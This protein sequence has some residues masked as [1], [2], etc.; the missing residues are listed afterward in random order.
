MLYTI[1]KV[2]AD[3]SKNPQPFPFCDLM[4]VLIGRR[5]RVVTYK[6]NRAPQKVEG[7]IKENRQKE[8]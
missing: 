5:K 6:A 7:Q 2:V 3:N 1:L 4:F 8:C